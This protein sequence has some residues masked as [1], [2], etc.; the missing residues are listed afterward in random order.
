MARKPLTV[1]AGQLEQLASGTPL[2]VGGWNLPSA[3]GTLSYVLTADASGH[4]VWAEVASDY[5]D[6][7]PANPLL[8]AA[9]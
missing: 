2:D 6:P 7:T 3:G 5:G 9:G 4:A 8:V 1:N